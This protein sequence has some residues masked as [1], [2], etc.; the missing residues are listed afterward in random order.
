MDEM[1]TIYRV[2]HYDRRHGPYQASWE[3]M[4][5][6]CRELADKL[7]REFKHD[8]HPPPSSDG[9]FNFSKDHY[10]GF[11]SLQAL[12]DWFERYL[13]ELQDH[14]YHVAVF[15]VEDDDI[16]HGGKQVMFRRKQYRRKQS[17]QLSEVKK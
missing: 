11:D 17:L 8:Q 12:F 9:I 7:D 3:K 6:R 4:N 13:E 10:C 14:D 2:E 15:E 1:K 16:K 5:N